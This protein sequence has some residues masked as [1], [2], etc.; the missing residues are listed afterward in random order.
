MK[1]NIAKISLSGLMALALS[2]P[3][4][5]A[6]NFSLKGSIPGLSDSLKV[7]LN[8]VEDPNGEIREIGSAVVSNGAFELAGELKSPTVCEFSVLKYVPAR[9]EFMRTF[10]TRIIA[11]PGAM[12]LTSELPFDSLRN[13]SDD[14]RHV[15][16]TGS[17]AH[18]QF[19]RYVAAVMDAELKERDAS[20]LSAKKYFDSNGNEDTI[21]KYDAIKNAAKAD[22]LKAQREFI[23]AHPDYNYS[24]YLVQRELE[25]VF[26]YSADEINAMADLVKACPDTARTS[27][28][29]KRRKFAL[30]YALGR[31]CPEFE[32]THTDGKTSPFASLLTPGKYTFIDFWASWCGPC[33]SAIPHVRELNSK[34]ADRLNVFSISVDETE[35]PWRK[36]MDEEKMEWMQLHL[37][38]GDQITKGAQAF[39]ITTIPRLVLLNDKG[40][41]ICSTN[42]PREITACIEAEL[43]K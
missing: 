26:T 3:A 36:A 4:F 39:F 43:G 7:V 25:K 15:R 41:V 10:S 32:V 19:D 23:A 42:M 2:V 31:Q 40:E 12:T 6:D 37:D 22:L 27:T 17:E 18:S 38:A 16:V 5:A 29:E 1:P 13:V 30:K 33:R 8:D 35:E 28:V 21:V 11:E 34:Y 14:E 24:A 9:Q 20:Y